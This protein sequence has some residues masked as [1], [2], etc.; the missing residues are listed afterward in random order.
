MHKIY[1]IGTGTAAGALLFAGSIFA[2]TATPTTSAT[3]TP[4]VSVSPLVSP[5]PSK[6]ERKIDQM[7][8]KTERQA[9]REERRKQN[10]RKHFEK[11]QHRLLVLIRGL[12]NMADRIGKR[13]EV[14]TARGKDVATQKA[15]LAT[16]REEIGKLKGDLSSAST[17]LT[18]ILNDSADP[19]TAFQKVQQAVKNF[20]DRVKKA[21]RML[22]DII[23][24]LKGLSDK[25]SSP[26]P[27]PSVN[28]TPPPSAT[29]T[30]TVSATPTPTPTP[31]ATATPTPSVTPTPTP[32]VS[33][34]PTPTPSA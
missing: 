13:L 24:S 25:E 17:T 1:Q 7:E 23:V 11:M 12:E 21:H 3:P 34:T 5:K 6:I 14:L 16:V 33:V 8:R 9:E 4:S 32:S 18:A 22:I 30:P 26:T 2:Q 20:M 31:S 19:K 29:P 10:I 28:V 15:K 27:T